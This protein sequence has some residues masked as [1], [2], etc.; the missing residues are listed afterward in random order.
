MDF[1]TTRLVQWSTISWN[2]NH[3]TSRSILVD[4]LLHPYTM[5]LNKEVQCV[6]YYIRNR[7][8]L[9]GT[10]LYKP[11]CS[12]VKLL[13]QHYL[14]IWPVVQRECLGEKSH[15][16]SLVHFDLHSGKS[17][18][19]RDGPRRTCPMV[20]M[21]STLKCSLQ[22]VQGILMEPLQWLLSINPILLLLDVWNN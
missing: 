9:L 4:D 20:S 2:L 8:L 10:S 15:R 7:P 16:W 1:W 18:N 13:N 12:E 11:Y 19:P 17:E 21:D 6:L 5:P 3:Q 22:I 14:Q